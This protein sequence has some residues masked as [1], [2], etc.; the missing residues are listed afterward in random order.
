L[1]EGVITV[2]DHPQALQLISFKNLEDVRR[3]ANR[4]DIPDRVYYREESQRGKPWYALI[5]NL[6]QDQAAAVEAKAALPADLA[7]LKPIIRQLDAGTQ[8]QVLDRAP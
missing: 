6:Y 3:F 7:A 8:L 5:Y 2:G 1:V 4:P